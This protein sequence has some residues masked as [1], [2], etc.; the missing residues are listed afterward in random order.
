MA[1][2]QNSVLGSILATTFALTFFV[3]AAKAAFPERPVTYVIPFG[4]GGE[5]GIAARL[6]QPI[7]KTITGQDL[8]IKFRPGGG[9]AVAWSQLNTMNSDG[10]T[11]VGVNLPHILLQPLRGAKYKTKDIATVHI[12]HYTP[13]ALL[14]RRASR[15]KNLQDLIATMNAKPGKVSFSGSGRGTANH[16]AK[17]WFDKRLQ[18]RSAYQ[19]HKGTAAAMAA[20]LQEKVDASWAYTTAAVKYD[21]QIRM[22]A[23][24]MLERHPKFLDVPTFRELGYDFIGGAYRGIAV[25]KSSPEELRLKI[26][27]IFGEIG[28]DPNFEKAKLEIG[29][30]PIDIGYEK[31]PK[32]LKAQRLEYL[33]LA[34]EAGIID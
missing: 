8:V 17:A 15:Y 9:G 25:P 21:D 27:N 22:L 2:N 11:I 3:N 29:F 18:A 19:A 33:P 14:V 24:A 6:Q 5:S 10:H 28:F 34:R 30:V 12:F 20:M 7:F 32:F 16:L 1:K 4:V 31:I 26:S 23:V 13:H